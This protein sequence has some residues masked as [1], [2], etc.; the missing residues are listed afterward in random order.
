MD[1]NRLISGSYDEEYAS[2]DRGY[3]ESEEM[4]AQADTFIKED[5]PR[6]AVELL[7]KILQRNPQFG[8]AYNHLGWVYENKYKDYA[9]AEEYYKN[10]M[11][12][13]P[14][15]PAVYLNYAYFLSNCGRFEEL[16]AHLDMALTLPYVLKETIYNEYAIMYEMQQNPEEAINY[17]VQAA[18]STL[19]KDKL[20]RFKESINRC[21]T[22]I[23]LKNSLNNYF[24]TNQ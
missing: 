15:Y 9:H 20:I 1:L 18:M 16:K 23:E 5:R 17:Y 11:K 3:L 14:H 10:A 13:A 21:Q 6:E 2:L 7:L 12:Y 19:D 22:K 8:K 24:Q 4:F